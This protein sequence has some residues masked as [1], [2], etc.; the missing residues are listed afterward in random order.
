MIQLR[1]SVFFA[2]NG[3]PRTPDYAD[4]EPRR[5]L[6]DHRYP[7]TSSNR[8]PGIAEVY[9]TVKCMWK[10]HARA[11]VVVTLRAQGHQPYLLHHGNLGGTSGYIHGVNLRDDDLGDY[12]A[13]P[14]NEEIEVPTQG[15]KHHEIL[16]HQYL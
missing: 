10:P 12:L 3:G 9:V 6:P 15:L 16:P 1:D 8:V 14:V 4:G 11:A 13:Y 2:E 5:V 7:I